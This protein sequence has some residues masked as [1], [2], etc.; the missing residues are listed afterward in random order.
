MVRNRSETAQKRQNGS[1]CLA[2]TTYQFFILSDIAELFLELLV[3]LLPISMRGTN[4]F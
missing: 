4:L 2:P 1:T 3:F